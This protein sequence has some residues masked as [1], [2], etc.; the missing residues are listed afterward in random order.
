MWSTV[1]NLWGMVYAIVSEE[2]QKSLTLMSPN[3]Q[4]LVYL[5]G[6]LAMGI[7]IMLVYLDA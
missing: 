3:T 4:S 5:F 7:S 2:V 1:Y 6:I